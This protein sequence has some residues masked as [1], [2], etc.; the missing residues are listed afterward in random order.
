MGVADEMN[1]LGIV[2]AQSVAITSNASMVAII[3]KHFL[4]EHTSSEIDL[5]ID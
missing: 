4:L 2:R 3:M 5:A 1:V